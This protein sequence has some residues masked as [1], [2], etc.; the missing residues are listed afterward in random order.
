MMTKPGGRD[1]PSERTSRLTALG[2]S[3]TGL[4]DAG[5]DDTG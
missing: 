2:C 5:L 3:G 4:D 1:G